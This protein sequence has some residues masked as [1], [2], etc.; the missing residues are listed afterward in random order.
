MKSKE[1]EELIKINPLYGHVI[2]RCEVVS[3][4]EI[5]EAITRFP[6]ARDLDGIKRRTRAGMGRCQMGFCTPKI[7]EILARELKI[8]MKDV[9]K[10]GKNSK[11]I[12]SSIK[13]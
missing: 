12:V 10:K 3:E 11:L 5:V 1:L 13:E 6:G 2:C 8:E 9:T 7:M 4:A